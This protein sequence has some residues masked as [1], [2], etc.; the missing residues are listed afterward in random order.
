MEEAFHEAKAKFASDLTRDSRKI[1]YV[2]SVALMKDVE[3]EVN[4]SA[5]RY[6][7]QR[8]ESKARK[9]LGR[10][11]SRIQFYGAVLDVFAQHHPEYVSLAWGSIKFLLTVRWP[12]TV[13]PRVLTYTRQSLTTRK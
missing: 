2:N 7:S 9:W 3:D 8:K 10:L 11:S 1:D 13:K 4:R 5:T 12:L 6:E